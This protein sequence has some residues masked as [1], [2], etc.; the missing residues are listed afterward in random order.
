MSVYYDED[1]DSLTWVLG[2]PDAL[3]VD[4]LMA[5]PV[6][7]LLDEAGRVVEVELLNASRHAAPE[8]LVSVARL[9][10]RSFPL[11][12]LAERHG[13]T[14]GALLKAIQR[15]K[16]PASQVRGRWYA[17]EADVEAYLAAARSSGV[18]GRPRG[19]R[20]SA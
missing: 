18:A 13:L 3:P 16:L 6:A 8:A 19:P 12:E 17:T 2:G 10:L 14:R 5:G 15:G 20:R 1:A 7:I 9:S 4:T 11:V